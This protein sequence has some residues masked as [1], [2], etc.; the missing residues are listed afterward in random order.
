M[1]GA[2][3][4]ASHDHMRSQN[5]A[6]GH[7]IQRNT[8]A[9]G[10]PQHS[11]WYAYARF[12][13]R[14]GGFPSKAGC[15]LGPAH[16]YEPV[17]TGSVKCSRRQRERELRFLV[18][19]PHLLALSSSPLSAS[20]WV[21]WE[22]QVWEARARWRLAFGVRPC[23]MGWARWSLSRRA[24][25]PQVSFGRWSSDIANSFACLQPLLVETELLHLHAGR[26][27]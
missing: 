23:D 15:P 11:G 10:V 25:L 22:L 14:L 27:H 16:C 1:T 13:P 3:M 5:S 2:L 20:L 7:R 12:S 8:A 19:A 17:S 21:S 18:P 24:W 4:H 6:A 9:T 26:K